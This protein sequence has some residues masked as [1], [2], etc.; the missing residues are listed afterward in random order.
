[1]ADVGCAQC[2]PYDEVGPA[3]EC[4]A[5][6]ERKSAVAID[7]EAEKAD[8]AGWAFAEQS[9]RFSIGA[10]RDAQLVLDALCTPDCV[11]S[12]A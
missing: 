11:V 5:V 3:S 4:G 12:M 10:R 1:M 6:D 2:S 9:A 8:R 7:R